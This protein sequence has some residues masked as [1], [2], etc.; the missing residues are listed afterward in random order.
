MYK[1]MALCS[2]TSL[3]GLFL[4]NIMAASG[5]H[6]PFR[7]IAQTDAAFLFNGSVALAADSLLAA[8]GADTDGELAVVFVE[9]VRDML[10]RYRRGRGFD[11][12]LHGNDVH[13]DSRS[14]HGDHG[15]NALERHLSHQIKKG[16]D[17]R[18]L[19]HQL[20]VHDHE[21]RDT[22]D[23]N[24]HIIP[25]LPGRIL[26]V[27]LDA[28]D[29][30]QVVQ[31][32]IDRF[33]CERGIHFYQLRMAVAGS[34]LFKAEHE[35]YLVLVHDLVEA[36]YLRVIRTNRMR[37]FCHITVGDHSGQ[38]GQQ[39]QLLLV[40]I[41]K[42]LRQPVIAFVCHAVLLFLHISSLL[43]CFLRGFFSVDRHCSGFGG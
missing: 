43:F 23:K 14:A 20:V 4:C 7:K 11:R 39:I 32:L 25:Q 19:C 34:R 1:P 18:M 28:A 17:I 8:A 13:A 26:A 24:R 27:C 22:G 2:F 30:H 36:P 10:E 12:L 42:V 21:F 3:Q 6:A 31:H 5:V 33:F 35:F 29:P 40:R 15:G 37:V 41:D 38:T 9:P 16:R